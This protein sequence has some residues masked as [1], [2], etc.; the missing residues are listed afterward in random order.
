MLTALQLHPELLE[1][2]IPPEW[3][4]YRTLILQMLERFVERLPL[5]RRAEIVHRQA[6]L[7]STAGI[8][9]RLTALL[10]SCP[11]LH[12]LGQMIARDRRLP[13]ELRSCLQWLERMP[14]TID[15]ATIMKLLREELGDRTLSEIRL[16]QRPLAEGSVAVIQPFLWRSPTT[17]CDIRGV[18]KVLKPGAE[19]L[20][21][22][23][24]AVWEKLADDIYDQCDLTG[25]PILPLRELIEDVRELLAHEV[26]L[27]GEQRNLDLA[28]SQFAN[29]KDIIIPELLPFCTTRVTAM[30][31]VDGCTLSEPGALTPSQRSEMA[32]L[33]IEA[34]LTL[35]LWTSLHTPIFHGDPHAGNIEWVLNK[36]SAQVRL[37]MLDWSLAATPTRVETGR[38]T[39]AFWTF[40]TGQ[41]DRLCSE[42]RAL[43][44]LIRDTQALQQLYVKMR[45]EQNYFGLPEL[46]RFVALLDT[47]IQRGFVVASGFSLL[48]RKSLLTL[49]GVVED[50]SPSFDLDRAVL[51][52]GLAKWMS[53]WPDRATAMPTDDRFDTH[54]SNYDI[55]RLALTMNLESL[56]FWGQS[57]WSMLSNVACCP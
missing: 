35:P 1:P 40:A 46:S 5:H 45:F 38:L 33:L 43:G 53:E 23:D 48:I 12:K 55:M 2:L 31:Q 27:I 28:S 7:P 8:P 54:V 14:P 11:T 6:M 22:E 44:L 37:V 13:P 49:Q 51:A 30:E 52:L 3:S 16:T 25:V 32:S 18:F 41:F 42:M 24:L 39:Q 19:S 26:Q 4:S 56:R 17:D 36:N 47:A 20:L 29:R 21:A 34:C 9:Q 50:V 15:T 57:W 10:A